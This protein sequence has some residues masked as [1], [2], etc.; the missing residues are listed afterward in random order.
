MIIGLAVLS[1]AS[2]FADCEKGT[3]ECYL[4]TYTGVE[5]QG[6]YGYVSD[7][8]CQIEIT[9]S[10]S[11]KNDI[12]FKYSDINGK[13]SSK[14]Q[15]FTYYAEMSS[16]GSILPSQYISLIRLK[17][18]LPEES[19]RKSFTLDLQL[20]EDLALVGTSVVEK[21]YRPLSLNV[22]FG[23]HSAWSA[24]RFSCTNL[25]KIK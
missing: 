5:L 24:P 7:V 25:V 15:K 13:V 22:L 1:S 6:Y 17:N 9:K 20:D 14:T 4:G 19:K 11:D 2:A 21:T 12:R 3:A 23:I 16:D 18:E 10:S 8:K